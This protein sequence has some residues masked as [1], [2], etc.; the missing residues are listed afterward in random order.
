M[1]N[2]IDGKVLHI[3]TGTLEQGDSV[4][5]PKFKDEIS[6]LTQSSKHPANFQTAIMHIPDYV[7]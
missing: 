1:S 6:V 2:F 4:H 3:D 5:L 7:G